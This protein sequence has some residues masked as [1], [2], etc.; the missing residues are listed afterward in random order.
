VKLKTEIAM[1]LGRLMAVISVV[2]L[3]LVSPAQALQKANKARQQEVAKRGS[4]VMPFTLNSI[5]HIF[6]KINSGGIQQVIVKDQSDT[7]QIR[8]IRE[9]LIKISK[10]FA[11]GDFSAPASIHGP[12]MPGLAELEKANS[13]QLRIEYQELPK[14]AQ[15]EYSSDNPNLI[16]AIH[17]WFDEQLSDHAGALPGRPGQQDQQ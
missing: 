6:E 17:R 11:R 5:L 8:M 13:G 15:I 7:G 9:H 10:E 14:D 16:D 12:D 3:L 1:M 4:Q 2:M